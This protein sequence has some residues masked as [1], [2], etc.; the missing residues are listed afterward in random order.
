MGFETA[1]SDAADFTGICAN[2]GLKIGD[3]VQKAFISVDENGTEAAA[4]TAVTGAPASGPLEVVDL[5]IDR[6]FL[7]FIHD[8]S[9]IV[10]FSG[11]VV[12]PSTSE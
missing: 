12:D 7:F 6:P 11:Q 9:G 2:G 4:A 8:D 5:T 1:L 3:V 10:L